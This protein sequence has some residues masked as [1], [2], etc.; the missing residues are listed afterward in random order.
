MQNTVPF[1][2]STRRILV[3]AAASVI[4]LA[5]AVLLWRYVA[6]D[7]APPE[8]TRTTGE[9]I[10]KGRSSYKNRALFRPSAG[11]PGGEAA[12][13]TIRGAVYA[14]DGAAAAGAAIAAATFEIAGNRPTVVSTGQS[15]DRGQFELKLPAGT[16][17]LTASM[18]GFGPGAV[19]ARSGE[20]VSIVLAKS[21]VL[22]GHVY[23][24]QGAPVPRFTLDVVPVI[25]NDLAA[26]APLMSRVFQSRDGSFEVDEVPPWTVV[27]RATA[28]GFAPALSPPIVVKAGAAG[29][30]D[31]TLTAGCT[32]VGRVTDDAGDPIA[33]VLVNAESLLTAGSTSDA[34]IQTMDEA[35]SD[36]EGIFRLTH[37]PRG[38]VLVRGYDGRSAVSTTDLNI[39][40]C[41]DTKPVTLVM[42]QGGS[43]AGTA[44]RSDGAPVGN[45]RVSITQR[46]VGFVNTM[47]DAQGRFRFDQIPPGPARLEL[48]HDGQRTLLLINVVDGEVTERD[49]ALFD[50]GPG[51]LKGRVTAGG[52]PLAGA[53]LMVAANHGKTLGMSSYYPMTD[54]DGLYHLP[55]I[56]KGSYLV[57]VLSTAAGGGIRIAPGQTALF[58]L[59]VATGVAA[60]RE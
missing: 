4:A 12:E 8:M 48:H 45:A 18:K 30:V 47:S 2:R 10:A 43:V 51:E 54:S 50:G 22:T 36:K 1:G 37:V 60:P 14:P 19:T 32:L 58:D 16:Y 49:I 27:L 21:A 55:Q 52:K 6:R 24:E 20:T 46:A 29:S 53:R 40:S 41:A 59:D 17:Q 11:A 34:S 15:D 26:P 42:A 57:T 39:A 25:S 3:A 38:H 9:Q 13:A 5:A 35:Y 44:R 28:E 56:P 33:D 31:L 23:D 7:A